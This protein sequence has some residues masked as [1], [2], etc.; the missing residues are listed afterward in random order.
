MLWYSKNSITAGDSSYFNKFDNIFDFPNSWR[1]RCMKFYNIHEKNH[2][3][4]LWNKSSTSILSWDY[5][6][7]QV[8]GKQWMS[9]L[10]SVAD[11]RRQKYIVSANVSKKQHF[12]LKE[13]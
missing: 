6:R 3:Q 8:M 10:L 5:I 7:T 9:N 13:K 2:V 12:Y 11:F 4:K 1:D